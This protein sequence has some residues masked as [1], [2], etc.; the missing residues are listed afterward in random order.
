MIKRENESARKD[1]YALDIDS[2]YKPPPE[3]P[4][5]PGMFLLSPQCNIS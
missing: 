4:I 5:K 3:R 2:T 1:L